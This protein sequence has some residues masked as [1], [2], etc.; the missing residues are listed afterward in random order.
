MGELHSYT[1]TGFDTLQEAKKKFFEYR[2]KYYIPSME[3]EMF[4]EDEESGDRHYYSNTA[5][6]IS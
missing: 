6:W 5:T 1:Y 2:D 3:A 4:I